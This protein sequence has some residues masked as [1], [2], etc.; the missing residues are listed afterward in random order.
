MSLLKVTDKAL[1]RMGQLLA[2]RETPALG[3]RFGTEEKGCSGQSYVV[4]YVDE[5]N[6]GDELV[7]LGDIKI[8]VDRD[9]LLFLIG[10][11]IDFEEA[12]F[13]SGFIFVNPNEKSRCGCGESFNV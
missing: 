12:K 9:S 3:L 8:F 7:E 2:A 5:V 4:D 13:S 11:T 1:E 6:P 10:T